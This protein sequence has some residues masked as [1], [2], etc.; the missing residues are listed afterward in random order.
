[1]NKI[2]DKILL[3]NIR[4]E[5]D[6]GSWLCWLVGH[7]WYTPLAVSSD[8]GDFLCRSCGVPM[9]FSDFEPWSPR[10]LDRMHDFWTTVRFAILTKCKLWI[11]TRLIHFCFDCHF[12]DMIF[13]REVGKHTNCIPF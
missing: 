11:S 4:M 8:E 5:Q 13:G 10:I 6:H 1:M 9:P 3:W 7:D 12:P 2:L